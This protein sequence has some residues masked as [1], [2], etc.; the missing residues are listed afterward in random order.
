MTTHTIDL[1]TPQQAPARRMALVDLLVD[2]VE[3]GASVGFV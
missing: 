3:G 2:S 1:L